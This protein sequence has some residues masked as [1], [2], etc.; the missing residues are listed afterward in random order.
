MKYLFKPRI[1]EDLVLSIVNKPIRFISRRM[2]SPFLR[3]GLTTKRRAKCAQLTAS[4]ILVRMFRLLDDRHGGHVLTNERRHLKEIDSSY[5][6]KT[7]G[8]DE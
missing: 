1:T 2:C 6:N 4:C 3:H 8:A 7:C 5:D